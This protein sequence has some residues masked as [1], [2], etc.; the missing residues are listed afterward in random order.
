MIRPHETETTQKFDPAAQEKYE[1]HIDDAI[2]SHDFGTSKELVIGNPNWLKLADRGA[3][4]DKYVAS[5]KIDGENYYSPGW[6][7]ARYDSHVVF[8]RPVVRG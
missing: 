7:V 8:T 3:V 2:S 6:H 4:L 1:R 5:Y